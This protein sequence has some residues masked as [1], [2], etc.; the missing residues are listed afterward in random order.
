MPNEVPEAVEHLERALDSGFHLAGWFSYE[1]GYLLESRLKPRWRLDRSDS[2]PLI[3]FGVFDPPR[4]LQRASIG[5]RGRAYA[6]PLRHGWSAEDYRVRFARVRRYIRDG[7]IYQANLSFRSYFAFAGDP[8]ALWLGLRDATAV[9]HGAFI[10]TGECQILSLSPELHFSLTAAGEMECRP[11][12]GTAARGNDPRTD[13]ENRR[14]LAA[15]SKDR[16]E[17]LMIVDLVRN[18]MGR[19]AET[20]SVRVPE[21]FRLETYPSFHTLV[22][23][24]RAQLRNETRLADIVKAL[25]PCG[26]IT[27]APKIRAMEIISELETEPRD[28]Y[29]GSIGYF[30]PDGAASLNVAIRTITI[31]N[32]TG[33]LG[34]GGAVVQ[35]SDPGA[36]YEECLLKAQFFERSRKPLILIETLRYSH[37]FVDLDRHLSR[38]AN[39]ARAFSL[40]FNEDAARDTLATAV[41]GEPDLRVRLTLDETGNFA[42]TA[43][44]LLPNPGSWKFVISRECVDSSD[45]LLRHKTGWRQLYDRESARVKRDGLDEVIF[46]NER[47]E[48]TE[49]SRTSLFIR[50]NGRLATPPLSSGLLNGVLRSKLLESGACAEELLHPRDLDDAPEIFLGSSLRGLIPAL[51]VNQR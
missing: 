33:V 23:V 13:D 7:D 21:L 25:F 42:A 20:G 19:I 40:P 35:D 36:E 27:G 11:M 48:L 5:L 6:G 51:L 17:N 12:K 18:D 16:A 24:V 4:T 26:S 37:G 9:R 1:L 39:S 43:E 22:S 31:K 32:G 8:L 34:L 49:G 29:C 50:R 10:D 30:A 41:G 2:P 28:V 45:P 46:R 47:G 44:P 3:W 38:M 14:A 15:S